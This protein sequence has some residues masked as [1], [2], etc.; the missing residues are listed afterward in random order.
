[1]LKK[2]V[3]TFLLV[4]LLAFPGSAW[5]QTFENHPND[6][7]SDYF[8]I[9][10]AGAVESYS[11]GFALRCN[12]GTTYINIDAAYINEYLGFTIYS[13]DGSGICRTGLILY[14]EDNEVLFSDTDFCAFDIGWTPARIEFIETESGLG[15]ESYRYGVLDQSTSYTMTGEVDHMQIVINPTSSRSVW[16]DDVS[17]VRG[18]IDCDYEL[19]ETATYQYFKLGFPTISSS[20]WYAVVTNPNNDVVHVTANLT[21]PTAYNSAN[22][23]YITQ[24]IPRTNCTEGGT[25]NIR[26]YRHDITLNKNYF[27]GERYFYYNL[28]SSDHLELNTSSVL[29]GGQVR[30][31][32][33]IGSYAPG[34]FVTFRTSPTKGD[35]TTV[36]HDITGTTGQEVNDI[37]YATIPADAITGNTIIYLVDPSGNVADYAILDITETYSTI[38]KVSLDKN[39]YEANDTVKISYSGAPSNALLNLQLRSGNTGVSSYV[40]QVTGS[41]SKTYTLGSVAAD[42]MILTLKENG[43]STLV[44]DSASILTGTF[45]LSGRVYDA[46]SGAAVEGANVL[47]GGNSDL[48]NTDGDYGLNTT[49]GRNSVTITCSGYEIYYGYVPVYDIFSTKN[50]WIVPTSTYSGN[51]VYG[52]VTSSGIGVPLKGVRVVLSNS[53]DSFTEY[54]DE[55]GYFAI[56]GIDNGTYNIRVSLSNYDTQQKSITVSGNTYQSFRLVAEDDYEEEGSDPDPDSGSIEDE[57][58]DTDYTK[59]KYGAYG[60]HAFDFNGDAKVSADEWKYAFEH[61]IV[62]IGCLCFMG[63][64]MIVGRAGRR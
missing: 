61:L 14:N 33:Y 25:Y 43:G 2:I 40:W 47:V 36:R 50:F 13:K 23:C 10:G 42:N 29:A 5:E 32:S 52:V 4:C 16:V 12:T 38:P 63:F 44:S 62:V 54:T 15:I 57:V 31:Y 11:N 7:D 48:T 64:L 56:E 18:V 9:S 3:F 34:Y 27:Y 49:A 24:Q 35:P 21:A 19:P 60:R 55:R 58:D 46:V 37:Y 45:Y 39:V 22:T 41:G 59:Q 51:S 6:I 17:S 53:T 26:L 30:I 8:S 28:P 20:T 1:M